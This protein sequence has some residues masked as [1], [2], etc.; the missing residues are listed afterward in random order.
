LLK[1][2]IIIYAL[3]INSRYKKKVHNL[4]FKKSSAVF[5]CIML[6]VLSGCS[7]MRD[8]NEDIP[9]QQEVSQPPKENTEIDKPIVD[10]IREQI[11]NMSLNEKVGQLV[12]AGIDSYENDVHSREL[13]EKYKVG[14]FILLGQNIKDTKQTLDLVNSLKDSNSK[15]KIPLFLSIDE[16]GG[17]ITRLPKEFAKLPT[18]KV[19]GEK[20]NSS[21]SYKIG[22]LLGEEVKA[23]GLNMN[24]A[25]VL[26]VNSNPQNP[27]I[28]DR[29]FGN[30]VDIV[31][32]L[33][34]QTMKGIQSHNIVAGVKHF[35]GHGDTSVDSHLG[36]PVVNNDL[37]RLKSLELIPFSKAIENGADVVM[38]AHILLPKID[39]ENPA[40]FSKIIITDVLREYLKYDGV[41]ITDDMTM[42]AIV[43]NY[44]IGE[45][46]V[47]SLNAGSDIVLVCHDFDKE[48]AVI[49]AINSAVQN[50]TITEKSI[51]EKVYRVLKLK[52]KYNI[53]DEKIN[54]INVKVINEKI[55]SLVK[56]NFK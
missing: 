2:I 34:I 31:S 36:L 51:D 45:A 40:S 17:R 42:G 8:K 27:V 28:G 5:I 9:K 44:D 19:I 39:K 15:N 22:S 20:N 38:I 32:K 26:D 55:N 4:N 48:T 23:F 7:L 53:K 46:A 14:G 41:V 16:E 13:I 6:S 56:D 50:K 54:S 30:N 12:I 47:K 52:Q 18:N 35:P 24:F 3:A 33:G 1:L 25:P 29:S 10:S 21:L 11:K 37:N 49:M 43:K